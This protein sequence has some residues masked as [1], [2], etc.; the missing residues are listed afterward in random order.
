MKDNKAIELQCEGQTENFEFL[1]AFEFEK[2]KYVAL[3]V[4]S[5]NDEDEGSV[6]I[7]LVTEDENKEEVFTTISE[8]NEAKRV[9]VYFIS[10]WETRDEHSD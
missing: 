4:I 10:L 6:A 7:F 2:K 5:E 9:W 1:M 3:E 8:E